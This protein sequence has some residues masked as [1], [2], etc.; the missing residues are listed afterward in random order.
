MNV[1]GSESSDRKLKSFSPDPTLPPVP[2]QAGLGSISMCH[3]Q[4]RGQASRPEGQGKSPPPHGPKLGPSRNLPH[5]K[6]PATWLNRDSLESFAVRAPP[7][8][9]GIRTSWLSPELRRRP[10]SVWV[11][12]E[13]RRHF[14]APCASVVLPVHAVCAAPHLLLAPCPS[15]CMSSTTISATNSV[16]C[17]VLS[18]VHPTCKRTSGTSRPCGL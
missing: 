3:V 1:G 11:K 2:C 6:E 7:R 12:R 4:S 5:A 14:T 9:R 16:R 18:D 15:T 17:R 10:P 13:E 8:V